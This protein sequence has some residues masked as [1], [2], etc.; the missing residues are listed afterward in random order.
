M[1]TQVEQQHFGVVALAE[2]QFP[3]SAQACAVTLRLRIPRQSGHRFHGKLDTQSSANWTVIPA[4]T[5][6]R[7][8]GK[9][10]T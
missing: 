2:L 8:H 9:L 6:H 1:R 7:F 10:D 5:G 3:H 4:Q